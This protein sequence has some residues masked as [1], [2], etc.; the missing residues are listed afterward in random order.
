MRTKPAAAKSEAKAKAAK[1]GEESATA[2]PKPSHGKAEGAAAAA[3][4]N[5]G[6]GAAEVAGGAAP[7]VVERQRVQMERAR[8][9]AEQEWRERVR[10]IHN[11]GGPFDTPMLS[12]MVGEFTKEGAGAGPSVAANGRRS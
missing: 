5:A 6:A 9:V 4:T 8:R 12:A 10:T 3:D 2:K 11:T 1:E 7:H